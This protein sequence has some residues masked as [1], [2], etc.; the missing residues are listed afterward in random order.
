RDRWRTLRARERT[1]RMLRQRDPDAVRIGAGGHVVDERVVR[2]RDPV[3]RD[4]VVRGQQNV[5]S[6][7]ARFPVGHAILARE[8]GLAFRS[9][10]DRHAGLR[11]VA[12]GLDRQ[13]SDE[14]VAG[15]DAV[16]VEEAVTYCVYGNVV[17]DAQ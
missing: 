5:A 6:E 12:L 1:A 2:I 17:L 13:V 16:L 7:K 4:R 9:E 10:I 15:L 11:R 3:G 8:A 14:L